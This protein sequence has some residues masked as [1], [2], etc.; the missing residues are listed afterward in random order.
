[1]QPQLVQVSQQEFLEEP[2][3]QVSSLPYASRKGGSP[4][5]L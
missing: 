3:G 4:L 2:H 1:M 5:I